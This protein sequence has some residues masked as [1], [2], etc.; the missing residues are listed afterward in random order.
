MHA[1]AE[2]FSDAV[3]NGTFLDQEQANRGFHLE[4]LRLCPNRD[5]VEMIFDLRNRIPIAVQRERYNTTF[6][7]RSAQEHFEIVELLLK[8]D[9]PSLAALVRRHALGT[10]LTA[11]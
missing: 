6:L 4:M 8:N 11:P 5:L 10:L 9:Q 3:A 7:Q 2:S 1:S